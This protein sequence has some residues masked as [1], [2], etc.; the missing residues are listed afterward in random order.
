MGSTLIILN[1]KCFMNLDLANREYLFSLFWTEQN[2][3]IGMLL[4]L[5]L[6]LKVNLLVC[7]LVVISY[8]L[9]QGQGHL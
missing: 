6:L 3:C 9:F 8:F 2:R 4:L 7:F 5:L 1:I